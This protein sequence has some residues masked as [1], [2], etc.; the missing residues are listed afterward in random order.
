M[1]K[2]YYLITEYDDQIKYIGLTKRNLSV[3]LKSHIYKAKNTTRLNKA[4]S[5]IISRINSGYDIIIEKIESNI[6]S[7]DEANE[8][9]KY[10]IKYYKDVGYDLKNG[11]EGGDSIKSYWKGKKQSKEHSKKIKM[12]LA[13]RK[14][15]EEHIETLRRNGIKNMINNKYVCCFDKN[16]NFYKEYKSCGRAADDLKI[17]RS[18]II[19][20]ANGQK[21]SA[22]GYFFRYKN[23]F[24]D[25]IV[26]SNIKI[27]KNYST[28]KPV[29]Q[30]DLKRNLIKKWDNAE[31]VIKELK[32]NRNKLFD[33]IKGRLES[34]DGFIFT[35]GE[36]K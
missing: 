1:Y 6:K 5:W 3:R 19:K 7:L 12:S 15:S 33:V 21:R 18:G 14:L 13:G 32:I 20:C 17:G 36:L 22:N 27:P 35:R 29:Y 30:Y 2:I 10:W 34:I 9:E 24:N 31:S 28:Y 23:T 11:T 16:G 8:R 26:P 4:Q 25:N